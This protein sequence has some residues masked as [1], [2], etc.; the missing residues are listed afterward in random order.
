MLQA[1]KE[2]I[3]V[4]TSAPSLSNIFWGMTLGYGVV[5]NMYGEHMWKCRVLCKRFEPLI[6]VVFCLL[7]YEN[8]Y[9]HLRVLAC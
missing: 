9:K 1:L 8:W 5:G 4:H 6:S 3:L 7:W 2:S